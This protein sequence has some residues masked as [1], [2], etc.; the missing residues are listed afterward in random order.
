MFHPIIQFH[1]MFHRF[2][3]LDP[4]VVG[5]GLDV[6]QLAAVRLLLVPIAVLHRVDFGNGILGDLRTWIQE[7]INQSDASNGPMSSG[8]Q[9]FISFHP[10]RSIYWH[11]LQRRRKCW[12][13]RPSARRRRTTSAVRFDWPPEFWKASGE[14]V[15]S[16]TTS[17][18][19]GEN[20]HCKSLEVVWNMNNHKNYIRSIMS[21]QGIV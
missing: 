20:L 2:H 8:I 16:S 6:I 1:P 4:D 9:L 19:S 21:N 15:K 17:R 5:V 7:S 18:N 12:A 10:T 3:D 14:P 11:I 13:S